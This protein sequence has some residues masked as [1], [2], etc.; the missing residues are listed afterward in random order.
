LQGDASGDDALIA[1]AATGD[2]A[3]FGSLVERHGAALLRVARAIAGDSL[4]PDI[5]QDALFS[6][7]RSAGTYRPGTS[8]V[9]TWLFAITRHVAVRARRPREEP[10][11]DIESLLALGVQAGWGAEAAVAQTESRDELAR[12]IASLATND[13]EVLVLCDV[14]GLT[15]AVAAT[16]V[17]V[18]LRALK[19]RLHRARLRLLAAMRAREGSVVEHERTE[20]GLSCTDVLER[21]GDYVDGELSAPE[22]ERV[23]RH[24]R[25]CAVCE[26]FGG[27]Y[28]SV[29]GTARLRLGVTPAVDEEIV[30][31][32]RGKL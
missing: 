4:A 15:L 17:G 31:R 25:G 27:R 1:K 3:S 29:V 5:V 24:L 28:A 22:R 14:E 20:G 32:I 19:S 10:V 9:R 2:R 11:A 7:F 6:A 18:E 30:A 26:R 8:S 13:R 16:V 23:D 12:A 21:L